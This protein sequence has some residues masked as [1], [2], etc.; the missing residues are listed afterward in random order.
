MRKILVNDGIEN[1][2][3]LMLEQAGYT[4][5]MNKVPQEELVNKLNEYDAI[6]VRSATKVRKEQIDA[7]PNLKVIARG[8]VGLDNIDVEYAKSKGIAVVNTPAASSRSVAE[9]AFAHIFALARFIH[10]AN[11]EMPEKGSSQFNE[12]KKQFAAGI[13]LEGK[14]IGII[15]MGRIGQEAAKIAI[16]MGMDV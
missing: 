15:G 4:V 10:L 3:K 6:C 16:G 14:T 1:S 13:E 5:D 2:G 11:R 12:L 9:L 8:G 7:A